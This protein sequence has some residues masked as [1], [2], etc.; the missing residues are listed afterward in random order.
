MAEPSKTIDN[1][2]ER[3]VNEIQTVR[4]DVSNRQ[5]NASLPPKKLIFNFDDKK[6]VFYFFYTI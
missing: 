6:D 1:L 3:L 5:S 2:L 4:S